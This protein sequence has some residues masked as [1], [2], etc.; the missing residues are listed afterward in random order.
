MELSLKAVHIVFISFSVLL[1][2]G[3][4]LWAIYFHQ[5]LMGLVSFA[6]G[7][8]LILYG[9]RFLRKLRHISLM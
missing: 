3:F 1:A 5:M 7:I 8:V 2:F 6:I 9:I 4:G